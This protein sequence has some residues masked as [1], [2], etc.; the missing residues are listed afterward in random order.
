MRFSEMPYKRPDIAEMSAKY[1]AITKKVKEAASV[2]EQLE[3]FSEHE[4]LYSN[5][6]T[7]NSIVY[8]RYSTNTKDE[9]YAKEQEFM[10]EVGPLFE[11]KLQNF[12]TA[13]LESKFRPE[14]EEKLGSLI[15]K[16]IE[17][18][19]RTFS[20]AVISLIQEENKLVSE[21]QRIYASC[22]VEIDGKKLPVTKLRPYKESPDR[23]T[24]KKAY[25]AEGECFDSH[26]R[27]FDEIY[28]K[29]VKLRSEIAAKLG[30]KSFVELAYDRLGRN[31]YGASE[32]ASLREQ[33]A[34]EI[35]PLVSEAKER[36]RRRI[37]V[38]KLYFYDD[39]F[40]FPDGNANPEGTAEEILAAGKEMYHKLSPE[41]AE[42]ID[43]M[44]E[45]ELFDVLAKEGKAPGGYCTELPDYKAPFI[46]SNFNG[47]AGDVDVLTHEA[48]HAFAGY[49]A[50]KH[51]YLL[52][53]TSPTLEG[54]EVHSMS[55]EFLT[56]EYHNLFFGKNTAKYELSHCEDALVFLPYGSMVDEFQHIV[57]ENPSLTPEQR[58]EEWMK[59]EKKYRPYMDFADIPFYS[60]GAGWQ[61][62]T[63]I[64]MNPFYYIDYC[65][66][67]T[68]A[69]Q[70]WLK[71]LEDKQAAWESYMK[72]TNLGGTK[73]FAEA[74]SYAG[75]K[76]P[77]EKGCVGEIATKVSAWLAEHDKI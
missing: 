75:M 8:I 32:V 46:F 35:V 57:Y 49:T 34:K 76:L 27:E 68:V 54:C 33:I 61:R 11:E 63:H 20:P 21:Y 48:G 45:N 17:I 28:D 71:M 1:E 51:G 39:L 24:R 6:L 18:A 66:A 14:L 38:D 52:E 36:Q 72:Y 4:K 3:A 64:Y 19:R 15:F 58:N 7:L 74:V 26:R 22:T 73:T 55:M 56:S 62:Q 53:T 67:Q 30:Y 69:F 23:E 31:C 40:C 16:N 41:T 12:Y 50:A 65:M 9:F 43:F 13:L 25:T 60:R 77:Y 47:T 2:E 5:S 29:L 59:L 44:F 70:F 37:G 10:D 42:F